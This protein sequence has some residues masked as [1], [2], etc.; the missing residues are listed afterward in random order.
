MHT[1]CQTR[2]PCQFLAEFCKEL[3]R[4]AEFSPEALALLERQE[5][6]GNVR[7]LR[8]VVLRSLVFAPAGGVI[9][10]D[11]VRGEFERGEEGIGSSLVEKGKMSS[12]STFVSKTEEIV[13]TEAVSAEPP[14]VAQDTWKAAL[15]TE[16]AAVRRRFACAAVKK[17]G[18]LVAASDF[19]GMSRQTLSKWMA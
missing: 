16:L 4:K 13:S 19:C 5:W 2:K 18:T 3:D 14:V 12:P 1:P 15:N 7:Q 17:Y 11:T 6:P 10:E 9:G 8:N